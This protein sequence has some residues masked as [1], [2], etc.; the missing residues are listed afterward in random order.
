MRLCVIV[1][2][3]YLNHVKVK[4]CNK[5][6][7]IRD[8]YT[9]VSSKRNIKEKSHLCKRTSEMV[10]CTKLFD[11]INTFAGKPNR[12]FDNTLFWSLLSSLTTEIHNTKTKSNK[13]SDN[14]ISDTSLSNLSRLIFGLSQSKWS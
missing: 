4:S 10:T 2:N 7:L 9:A 5:K 8:E 13:C 11:L 3:E 1:M 6:H 14:T 12:N